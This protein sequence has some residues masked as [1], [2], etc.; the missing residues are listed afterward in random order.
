MCFRKLYRL[1]RTGSQSEGQTWDRLF[2][3]GER[4]P[5]AGDRDRAQQREL[6]LALAPE[7]TIGR[8]LTGIQAFK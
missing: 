6:A 2:R 7:I 3:V 1:L 8:A 4:K 5:G